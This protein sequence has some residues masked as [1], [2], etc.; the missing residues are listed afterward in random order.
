M[1][2]KNDADRLLAL[3][4]AIIAK[5]QIHNSAQFSMIA[6]MLY[7]AFNEKQG[8][9][10]SSDH[11]VDL[12]TM[13]ASCWLTMQHRTQLA[14]INLYDVRQAKS[15]LLVV[16]M[17][18]LPFVVDSVRITVSQLTIQ[19]MTFYNIAELA[20]SRDAKGYLQSNLSRSGQMDKEC[21]VIFELSYVSSEDRA[22]LEKNLYRVLNDVNAAVDDWRKMQTLLTD[23]VGTWDSVASKSQEALLAEIHA[24]TDWLHDYFTFFG[25]ET[26]SVKS[27]PD[28][29]IELVLDQ[30]TALGICQHNRGLTRVDKTLELPQRPTSTDAFSSKLFYI[31]KSHSRC[32]IHRDAYADLLVLR[33][34]DSN[35]HYLG[36]VRFVGLLSSE[37]YDADPSKIP[38]IRR[39]ITDVIDHSNLK[40]RYSAKSLAHI[41]KNIPTDELFQCTTLELKNAGLQQLAVRG[42]NETRVVI[43]RDRLG[44]FY[45]LI[46]LMPKDGYNSYVLRKIKSF[47][48][49]HF[50]TEEID[51]I[52]NFTDI[53]LVSIYFTVLANDQVHITSKTA[54]MIEQK[55]KV[56]AAPWWDGVVLA[57]RSKTFGI[58]YSSLVKYRESLS[59]RYRSKYSGAEVVNDIYYLEQLANSVNGES[60]MLLH[61]DPITGN[62]GQQWSIKIYQANAEINLS[63]IL[64]CLENMHLS[65]L[66]EHSVRIE[67]S[68]SEND[69]YTIT[70]LVVNALSDQ[71]SLAENRVHEMIACVRDVYN[72]R[73]HN[74]VVNRLI[75]TTDISYHSVLLV[76]AMI[77]YA[78]QTN[79]ALSTEYM[80]QTIT[81]Y[82]GLSESIIQL[83]GIRFDPSIQ[84][85]HDVALKEKIYASLE[86]LSSINE[87]RVFRRMLDTVMAIVRTNFYDVDAQA[88]VLKINPSLLPDMPA[89]VP[90]IET[91]VFSH[92][93]VGT[94]LRMSLISR[95]G[96]RWSSR[97][98]DYR[99][100]VL[101]LMH[102]QQ[103][104]NAVI[105]PEGAK[106]VFVPKHLSTIADRDAY[107]AEGLAC[108]QIFISS[109]VSIS[110]NYVDGKLVK[111]SGI[112]CLDG[113]DTYFV[114]A[115]DKGTAT[116]SDYANQIAEHTNFWLQDAFASGGQTGYDHKKIGITAK[117]AWQ[118]V[119][120]HF[121]KLDINPDRDRFTVVGIGDMS[122]DVFGNGMLLSKQIC[123]VA[124][125]DHR[126]IFIDPQ[127]CPKRSFKERAR[128]FEL[129][130]SSWDDYDKRLISA[131]G[132]VF[133]R[134]S[135]YITL[136]PE[137]CALLD[138]DQKTVTPNE[139]IKLI[140]CAQVDLIWNG[141]IGTYIRAS[142]ETD[143]DV[144]DMTNDACRVVAGEVRALV[145]AEGGNLG[146]TQKGRIEYALNG[147]MI[148]TDFIDNVGGVS[149]SDSEVNLKIALSHVTESSA[150]TLSKR[151]D[152]LVE[153]QESVVSMILHN[154]YMQNFALSIGEIQAKQK[155]E[156]YLRYMRYLE[157][158]GI[159]NPSID[160]LPSRKEL[161][162]RQVNDN[163][164]VRSELAIL[165]AHTK[166]LL[167]KCLL[168]G[169]LV[170]DPY[171]LLYL[172]H[173]FPRQIT[174]Q[175]RSTLLK[176][177]LKREIIATQIS[178]LCINDMGLSFIQQM[179]D[180]TRCTE[181]V[182]VKAYFI[183]LEIFQLRP[184]LNF[185]Y[186][187]ID[188]MD[189]DQS[190]VFFNDI[191]KLLMSSACWLVYNLDLSAPFS[192]QTIADIFAIPVE[193]LN[194]SVPVH[195]SE[196][197][198]EQCQY[199]HDLLLSYGADN[200]VASMIA[201]APHCAPLLNVVWALR[202]TTGKIEHFSGL[203]FWLSDYWSFT[204]LRA[205]IDA[206]PVD[207]I[208][209]QVAKSSVIT[210]LDRLQRDLSKYVFLVLK[211]KRNRDD[212]QGAID[213]VIQRNQ[214]E[215]SDWEHAVEQMR[216]VHKIDLSVITVA[217]LRLNKLCSVLE[218]SYDVS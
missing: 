136:S 128:L 160:C 126:H 110:D 198:V 184:A 25:A 27:H 40:S 113:D 53:S 55:L 28:A 93:V 122:G 31:S 147:G 33:M 83:F 134:A 163:Y 140:L 138:I 135:K 149:C 111:P 65:V 146:V 164:L 88:L 109:M 174:D 2:K 48:S 69:F 7:S 119:R 107:Y 168:Q 183:S 46:L 218:D 92:R 100:E 37:A 14:N 50:M 189:S 190:L 60:M 148:N 202:E 199:R 70:D 82:P 81:A 200:K 78:K 206:F 64:P 94:H 144:K 77:Y 102:A 13:I 35:G 38:W 59:A 80:M 180:E 32:H 169:D 123:L 129:S 98:E 212:Y 156:I 86:S 1:V 104:K 62:V 152:L 74:D 213:E 29:R 193:L 30:K 215:C 116:F 150:L 21:V 151:N 120:W 24:Y 166:T 175:Y 52:V 9:F 117:G 22:V 204:W 217:L 45:T 195:I 19:I 210:N 10:H 155:L 170:D 207:S 90:A 118:S 85:R 49:Q 185:I 154:C 108:Y 173:A 139:L 176:H 188:T 172:F 205:Q 56:I 26:Y 12:E 177:V 18:D 6:Q 5:H 179:K 125:F 43:R 57:Y 34:F 196:Q 73:A 165:Y 142:T 44:I 68:D 194:E 42:I 114:V 161:M 115:A 167:V 95:G 209:S 47:I 36:E 16:C 133:S 121:M 61:I 203:Y 127:P 54:Q 171:C 153:M 97:L 99:T 41:L 72:D 15:T 186:D 71:V 187:H 17:P 162:S 145:I 216:S 58:D 23:A 106:G 214:A 192:M 157:N 132:G 178:D 143:L 112:V 11:D 159:S 79:F 103:L 101:G 124:A 89:P 87:D 105:V 130:R 208:W 182:A 131:G 91:F 141:G 39:K 8:F 75:T 67:K 51:W 137:V 4:D 20:L 181:E 63:K 211:S 191:R 84:H 76:R 158:Q 197:S 96:I 201:Y 66:R 3:I